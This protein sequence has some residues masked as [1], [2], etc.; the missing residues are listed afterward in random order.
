M[1][2]A[3]VGRSIHAL[4]FTR[5]DFDLKTLI[6]SV[7]KTQAPQQQ[8]IQDLKGHWYN[9]R[10]RA[11]KTID[12]IL[13]GVV[14][15]FSDIQT[16]KEHQATAAAFTTDL[17]TRVKERTAEL[18]KSQSALLQSEKMEAVGRLAGGVAH[19]FNNLMTGILGMTEGIRKGLGAKSPYRDDLDEVVNAAKKAMA[20][21]KQ[22]LTFGRRQVLD[23]HVLNINSVIKGMLNLLQKFLGEDIELVTTLDPG[24]GNVKVDPGSIEQVILNL[25]LNARDSM[26]QGGSITLKTSNVEIGH[27]NGT[28]HLNMPPGPYVALA[29]SDKGS[30]MNAE[31]LE[32]IFEPFFTTKVDGKGTGLG[33]ATIY[34]IVKHSRGG[35]SVSSTPGQGTTF[36]IYLPRLDAVS[37]TKAPRPPA[38]SARR[39]S[40]TILVTED[41]RIVRKVLVRTLTEKGYTVLHAGSGKD[42]LKV[43][44][45]HTGRID[46]LLTDVIMLGMNGRALAESLL[47]K[48]P[49]LAILYMSGYDREI[50]AQRGV[51]PPGIDFIEK[52][53]NSEGLCQKVREVLDAAKK[54]KTDA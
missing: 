3:D 1:T 20:V 16:A 8:E 54:R 43:S 47:Q 42:A 36:T 17:E 27:T 10:I 51:L 31:T 5:S 11:Y 50:I 32:H 46:L 21:T 22:L 26:P 19:D 15:S 33:L 30:G 2:P 40:E 6:D 38:E 7:L 29:V 48:R 12:D 53:F 49:G 34:G 4:T 25:G 44:A 52:S 45:Q 35:I 39:G 28:Y 18:A 9:L 23:P 24:L 41:E 13:D 14:L 37:V